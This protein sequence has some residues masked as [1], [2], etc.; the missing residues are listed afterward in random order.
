MNTQDIAAPIEP[1][2]TIARKQLQPRRRF[3]GCSQGPMEVSE[4][5]AVLAA[6]LDR[7]LGQQ[8]V[9]SGDGSKFVAA[10]VRPDLLDHLLANL[11]RGDPANDR[12]TVS[13]EIALDVHSARSPGRGF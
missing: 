9:R 8:L 6:N 4:R 5:G 12:I 11:G 7:R 2:M 10:E 1:E 13:A 3:D